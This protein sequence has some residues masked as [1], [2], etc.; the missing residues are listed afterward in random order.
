MC[1]FRQ[2]NLKS[3]S[4]KYSHPLR[5]CM[6][7][8]VYSVADLKNVIKSYFIVLK[9]VKLLNLTFPYVY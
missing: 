9:I 2:V 8:S 4:T 6:Q 5:C 3:F 1:L 7:T